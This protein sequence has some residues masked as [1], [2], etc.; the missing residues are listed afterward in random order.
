MITDRLRVRDSDDHVPAATLRGFGCGWGQ[1]ATWENR[2]EPQLKGF[3]NI[4]QRQ[5]AQE[6]E[7][8][9]PRGTQLSLVVVW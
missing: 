3:N 7:G 5:I 4:G 9:G 8:S 2:M 6:G 1:S